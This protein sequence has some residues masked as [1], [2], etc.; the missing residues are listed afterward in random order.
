MRLKFWQWT[1]AGV[2][3]GFVLGY[4]HAN[5]DFVPRDPAARVDLV[6]FAKQVH[7]P[8]MADGELHVSDVILY[9]IEDG[10]QLVTFESAE[11]DSNSAPVV[12]FRF[13]YSDRTNIAERLT[14]L[15]VPFRRAWW[16]APGWGYALWGGGSAVIV[17]V[18]WPLILWMV[19]RAG[20]GPPLAQVGYDLNRFAAEPEVSKAV[21]M[22]TEAENEKLR[23]I[24]RSLEAALTGA[25]VAAA[26]TSSGGTTGGAPAVVKR[27]E[28]G[29]LDAA[30]LRKEEED[31]HYEGEY[32]PVAHPPEKKGG[33]F[34][35]VELLVVIAIIGALVAILLPVL[36]RAR[37]AGYQIQCAA[38]L[39][40]IGQGLAIYLN[41]NDNTYPASYLYVGETIVNGVEQPS[42][43]DAG[44]IHWS[45]Y[46]YGAMGLSS[47]VFECPAMDHG[48]IP[49]DHTATANLDPGQASNP[50]GIVDQQ[51]PRLAYTLN[52]AICPRNKFVLGFQGCV[53]TYSYVKS[54]QI[55]NSSGTI[56]A[57][58][59][60]QNGGRSDNGDGTFEVYS[61]R[62]VNGYFAANG[63]S[64][65]FEALQPGAGFRR[66][67]AADLDP[68][69]DTLMYNNSLSL[70]W[71]GRNH[72]QRAGY[73]DRRLSNFLY[74]DGHVETKSVYDT[75][76][77]FQWGSAF[78]SL[79]P[80]ED[81][82]K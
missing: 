40:S 58:E 34:T 44:Y 33:G 18:V 80:R 75:L 48:G 24:E 64:L 68:D 65:E 52:E 55:S 9:P 17:G 51:A 82:G 76:S 69:P 31:K 70:D 43:S 71:V 22:P 15:G 16:V 2:A 10:I 20:Y 72:G 25:G 74:V 54:S 13:F 67:T 37:S 4:L 38:N 73:I 61:H 47:T 35:I 79:N 36:A 78:W 45:S 50:P 21:A 28:G 27:L 12:K 81:M 3:I 62:P 32:Y 26:E 46:L 59:W 23:E 6:F 57:T 14:Q 11:T 56:L 53:R 66:A 7:A 41:Q 29:P 77:P 5:G 1:I 8:P 30:V 63:G 39:R 49:P 42:S 19:R 60:A